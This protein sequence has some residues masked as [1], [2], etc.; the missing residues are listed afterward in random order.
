LHKNLIRNFKI[1]IMFISEFIQRANKEEKSNTSKDNF[2]LATIANFTEAF[3]IEFKA[4]YTSES[5]SS[6]MYT[7]EGVYRKSDHWNSSV[8]S[9]EWFLNGFSTDIKTIGFCKWSDFAKKISMFSALNDYKVYNDNLEKYSLFSSVLGVGF[10]T[11]K[12][13][14]K[15]ENSD[16][17][18]FVEN[19]VFQ[20]S[21]FAHKSSDI[22]AINESEFIN[23]N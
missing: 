15:F 8:A 18:I 14:F 5:G 12:Q 6:Y 10:R 21:E 11:Y 1:Y 20:Y 13:L 3:N 2:Y 22:I 9:C 7:N 16:K 23:L 17:L 4:D 19:E